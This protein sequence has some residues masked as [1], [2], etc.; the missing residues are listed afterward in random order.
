M[1][2]SSPPQP[3]RASL[4]LID[5]NIRILLN[6]REAISLTLFNSDSRREAIH[7]AGRTQHCLLY[8]PNAITGYYTTPSSFSNGNSN[9]NSSFGSA[10]PK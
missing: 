7:I 1:S 8:V 10:R 5:I 4:I 2:S 3:I 9:G 6:G